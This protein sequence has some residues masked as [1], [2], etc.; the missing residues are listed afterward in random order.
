MIDVENL[1][2]VTGAV[3]S[4]W[5]L[6]IGDAGEAHGETVEQRFLTEMW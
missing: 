6:C 3:S 5:P 1:K 2:D 4:S